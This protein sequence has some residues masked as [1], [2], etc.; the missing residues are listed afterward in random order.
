MQSFC[1]EAEIYPYFLDDMVTGS[2]RR[3]RTGVDAL[4]P[5]VVRLQPEPQRQCVYRVEYEHVHNDETP[6]IPENTVGLNFSIFFSNWLSSANLR[7][8]LVLSAERGKSMIF[9]G[10]K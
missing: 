10:A 9:Q 3:R 5:D 8:P 7:N 6:G 1:S 4:P 2:R